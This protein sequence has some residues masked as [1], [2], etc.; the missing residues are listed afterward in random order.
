M[1]VTAD[2]I[3]P[4]IIDASASGIAALAAEFREQVGSQPTLGELLEIL[5]WSAHNLFSVP[6]AFKPKLTG[7]RRYEA[8][9]ASLVGELND[10]VFVDAADVL[11]VLAKHVAGSNKM[12]ISVSDFA[13]A[14]ALVLRESR[15]PM[16]GAGGDEVSVLTAAVPKRIAKPKIGDIL[17]IPAAGG[18]YHLTSVVARN[19]F[20][21]ALGLIR[22]RFPVP[23]IRETAHL[24]VR[25]FPVYTDDRLVSTG[26]WKVVGHDESLL[27]LFPEEPEIYHA[28]DLRLPGIDLGEFGA[29]ET[30][31]GEIR[32]VD[33]EEAGAVGLAGGGYQQAYMGES[34]MRL[35]DESVDS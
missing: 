27:S 30:P 23:R 9:R 12:P 21:T 26:A 28:P 29:A 3:P 24:G 6:L 16:E 17:A 15:I 34:L 4:D 19:R 32:L 2:S 31:S 13:S 10:S 22:G 8:P 20:G 7:N 25:R 14:L 5:G 1:L 18:G 33:I 11:S 35:L